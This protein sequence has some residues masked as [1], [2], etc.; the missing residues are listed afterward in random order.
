MYAIFEAS[1][2]LIKILFAYKY[3]N[4]NVEITT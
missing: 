3:N 4:Q 1:K 2:L